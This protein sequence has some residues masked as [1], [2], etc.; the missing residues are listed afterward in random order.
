ML[1]FYQNQNCDKSF[2]LQVQQNRINVQFFKGPLN[3]NRNFRV[4]VVLTL[5]DTMKRQQRRYK[6]QQHRL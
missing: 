1:S 2:G 5:F 6:Q 4:F 3:N